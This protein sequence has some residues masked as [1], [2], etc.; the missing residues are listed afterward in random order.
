MKSSFHRS[1]RIKRSQPLLPFDQ[2]SP[3]GSVS[4]LFLTEAICDSWNFQF[5]AWWSPSSW[6]FYQR[7]CCA[8]LE[9]TQLYAS[10]A[11]SILKKELLHES[12][13][14]WNRRRPSLIENK[15]LVW[16]HYI[17]VGFFKFIIDCINNSFI[18]NVW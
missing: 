3:F 8:E 17:L 2:F 12:A 7:G 14:S 13:T 10:V 9:S 4:K 16:S 15:K 11:T 18:L 5:F 1:N 6:A